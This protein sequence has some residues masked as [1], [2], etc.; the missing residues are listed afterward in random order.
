MLE[1]REFNLHLA[2]AR[3]GALREDVEDERGA[4]ENFALEDFF[5]VAA[6]RG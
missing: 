5:E 2:L 3:A 4:V 6:L 1:L